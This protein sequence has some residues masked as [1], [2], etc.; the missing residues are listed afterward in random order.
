[1]G[2]KKQENDKCNKFIIRGG[3]GW[4]WGGYLG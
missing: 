4:E 2:K 3:K 1:M